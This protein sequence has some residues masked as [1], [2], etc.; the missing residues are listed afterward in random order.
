MAM[1]TTDELPVNHHAHQQP[2]SGVMGVIAAASMLGRGDVARLA[3]STASVSNGDTVADI[4]CGPGSISRAAAR[5]GATV[6]GVDPAPIML[7]FA[8]TFSRDARITFKE[9]TAEHL[10]VDDAWASVLWSLSSV[11]HWADVELGLTEA[12]RV[13]RD[14][15]RLLVTER[16][17]RPG[18]TGHASHG[19]TDA[20]A[21]NFGRICESH[22]F[23]DL[24]ID[25]HKAGK[26]SLF[27]VT[28]VAAR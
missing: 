1:A 22:G 6:I 11:H 4:G 2:F 9:G 13:M 25:T 17:T 18:A 15:G 24:N 16:R 20:Q 12:H 7:R 27:V 21:D 19:W 3:V 23:R 8:H 28:G 26:H 5:A 14:G 10:P